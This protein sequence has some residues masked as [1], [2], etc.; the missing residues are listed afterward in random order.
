MEND[1]CAQVYAPFSSNKNTYKDINVKFLYSEYPESKSYS[2]GILYDRK[3]RGGGKEKL[4]T[5]TT[6]IVSLQIE[7]P[8]TASLQPSQK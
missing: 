6:S 7:F 8:S 2:L 4:N 5:S 3:K 1:K